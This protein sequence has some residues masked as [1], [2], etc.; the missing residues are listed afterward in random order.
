LGNV[1]MVD[2]VDMMISLR[3]KNAVGGQEPPVVAKSGGT[4]CRHR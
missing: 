4:R 1:S 3:Q 2:A